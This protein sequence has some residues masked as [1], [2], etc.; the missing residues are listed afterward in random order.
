[1]SL[2][3]DI[4]KRLHLTDGRAVWLD[5]TDDGVILCT[6]PQMLARQYRNAPDSSVDAFIADRAS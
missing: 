3:A 1:M 5:E 4:R 2:P 6:V